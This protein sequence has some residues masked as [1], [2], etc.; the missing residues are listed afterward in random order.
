MRRP[1]GCEPSQIL[2]QPQLPAAIV[3]ES[4]VGPNVAGRAVR[5][6]LIDS[7]GGRRRRGKRRVALESA[8]VGV[9]GRTTGR[10]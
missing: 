4:S 3:F 7:S 5:V 6:L 10:D 1:S 9:G 2:P 8:E